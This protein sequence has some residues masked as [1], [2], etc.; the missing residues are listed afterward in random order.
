MQLLRCDNE[1]NAVISL[2]II[3]EMHK[4]YK[5]ALE[6]Q[7]QPFFD[8]VSEMY[9]NM[10]QA[11]RETFDDP[12]SAAPGSQP[13]SPSAD[14]SNESQRVLAKSLY[15]FKVLTDCPMIIA[16]LFNV[17]KAS[18]GAN[19]PQ[20][21]PLIIQVLLLQP[22]AQKKAHDEAAQRGTIFVGVSPEIRN[23]AAYGD[24]KSL[25][26]V[27]FVAYILRMYA[28]YMKPH[29]N[30]VAEAVVSLL[31]DCPPEASVQRKE[32]LVASRHIW[33]TDFRSAFVKHIDTLLN[34]DVLSGTGV[35]SRETLRPLAFAPSFQTSCAKLLSNLIDCLGH[36]EGR[37]L[38]IRILDAFTQK[39]TALS[40]AFTSVVISHHK[41]KSHVAV[42]NENFASH[43]EMD[44]YLDLGYAQ[45]IRTSTKMLDS[46]TDVVKDI[47]TLLKT[48]VGAFKQLLQTLR[49][50]NPQPG[51]NEADV[52][53][54]FS[55]DE[56]QI[57]VRLFCD[58][59]KCF[60]YYIIENFGPDGKLLE[61]LAD[62]PS[63]GIVKEDKEVFEHFAAVFTYVEPS[64]FQEIFSSQIPLLF[65]RI[66]TN[67]GLQAL[68]QYLLGLVNT[69]NA[70][71]AQPNFVAVSPNF[72]GLVLRFLVDRLEMLGAEDQTF[73]LAMLRMFKIVFM[74]VSKY[75][76]RNEGVLRPHVGTIILKSMKLSAKAK[77]PHN[78]FQLLRNL[79]RSIGGGRFEALY[80]EVLPLLEVLLEGLNN[81]LATAHKQQMKELFVELCLT[82]PVRLSVLLPYLSYLMKPLVIALQAGPELVSQGLRTLE[83]C[84][85]NLTQDFLEP[86]LSPVIADL[87]AGLWRH[88]RPL[89]YKTEHSHTTMR[90]LG[91]LGGRNRRL[92][93]ESLRLN[94]K[95]NLESGLD[96]YFVFNQSD[97]PQM[98]SL[99][100]PLDVAFKILENP[101][102]TDFAVQQAFQFAR[103][104]IPLLLDVDEN[105]ADCLLQA[106]IP[107]DHASD[108]S[109]MEIDKPGEESVEPSPFIPPPL[110]SRDKKESFDKALSKVVSLFL[111]ATSLPSLHDAAEK[112]ISNL[113][114]HFAL[115]CISEA[116]DEAKK[117]TKRRG[118]QPTDA[119]LSAPVT[120]IDGFIDAIVKSFTS[121]LPEQ[122]RFAEKALLMFTS[123]CRSLLSSW[124]NVQIDE[125]NVFD[126]LASRFCSCC[127][128]Q[129]WFKKS[130]G[131]HGISI[132]SS[133]LELGTKWM[134][135]HELDFVKALLYVLKDTSPEM[136]S[137]NTED[138][139]ATLSHVLSVCN[140]K[141][142]GESAERQS[143]FSSLISLLISELSNSNSTVRETIQQTFQLLATL[144]ETAVTDLLTPLPKDLLQAGL[145]PILVNLSDFKRLSVSGLEGLARLLELLPNYFKVEVGKK[146][147]DHLRQWADPSVLEDAAGKPLSEIEQIKIMVAILNVFHLLPPTANIFLDDL[148]RN[149]LDLE[150]AMRRSISSPFRPPL[151]KFLNRYAAESVDYFM[152]NLGRQEYGRLF[153]HIIR[154]DLAISLRAELLKSPEKLVEKTFT[155]GE[156]TN[157]ALLRCCYVLILKEMSAYHPNWIC[158][159]P[160]LLKTLR[161]HW[162]FLCSSEEAFENSLTRSKEY[163]HIL[164]IFVGVNKSEFFDVE[165]LY[166]M[167]Q[168]FKVVDIL[169][170]GYLKH[171]LYHDCALTYSNDK[172]KVILEHFLQHFDEASV[173]EKTISLRYMIIPTLLVSFSRNEAH[174]IIDTRT[175]ELIHSRIWHP[176]LSESPDQQI[177]DDS[178]KVELLQL[179][180]LLVQFAPQIINESRRDVIKFAW[181]HLKL[182]DVTCK[183]AAYVLLARFI[184]QYDTP[185]KIVIQIFVALLRAHQ[186]EGRVL[187]KQALDILIPVLPRRI[188]TTANDS[189]I[190]TWVRWTRKI[191]VEEGNTSSQLVTIYQLLIRHAD[192]FYKS[193]DHFIPQIVSSV[194]KLGLLPTA[195]A[196][197]KA[198]TIELGELVLAWERQ[199]AAEADGVSSMED[200][201]RASSDLDLRQGHDGSDSLSSVDFREMLMGY[202]IKFV[203]V[204]VDQ[205]SNLAL[206]SR[207]IELMKSFLDLWPDVNIKFA[208][209]EKALAVELTDENSATLCN[210]IDALGAILERKSSG[211]ILSNI[212]N[213]QR[214]VEV[215]IKSENPQVVK[216]LQLIFHRTYKAIHSLD[217]RESQMS[218]ELTS[219]SKLVEGV[220]AKGLQG[221]TNIFSVVSLV[222]A[223]C[224]FRPEIM[225]EKTL[226]DLMKVL[227]KLT[228]EYLQS[229]HPLHSNGPSPV[230]SPAN[231]IIKMLCLLKDYVPQVKE[232]RK[233]FND[234]LLQLSA[235][236]VDITI[237]EAMLDII[238]SWIKGSEAFPTIKEKA[239]LMVKMMVFESLGDQKLAEEYLNLVATIY[240]TP[241]LARTELTVRLERAFMWGTKS[242]DPTIR[243]TFCATFNSSLDHTL[244]SRLNYIIGIQNWEHLANYFW[245]KQA[246]DLLIGC[247]SSG[248]ELGNCAPGYRVFCS[249]VKHQPDGSAEESNTAMEIEDS[250]AHRA[251]H[252]KFLAGLKKLKMSELLDP[253]R[254]M[255]YTDNE[256][257]SVMWVQLF[258]LCWNILH[259]TERQILSKMLVPLLAKEFHSVQMSLR[260]N[261]IQTLLE[262]ICKCIP[263]IVLP[264]QLVKYLGRSFN[265][266]YTALELLQNMANEH[267]IFGGQN[268]TK[269]DEKIRESTLDALGELLEAV[270]EDDYF[271]GLV[272]RRCLFAETNA[273]VSFEQNGMWAQA[274][275]HYENAQNK[276]RS[277][278]L[279]FSES[280]YNLWETH[281][282][283]SAQRLQQWDILT[284]V[285]KHEGNSEL[286]LECAWRL[287]DWM[288]ER[289][290][291]QKTVEMLPE[292]F[293]SRKKNIQNSGGQDEKNQ[294]RNICDAG[295]QMALKNW[296]ALPVQVSSA[297]I[298][299]LH[300][301]QQFVELGEAAQMQDNLSG[302]QVTNIDTKSQELKGILLTWRERLP[303]MWDDINIWSDLVAWRQHVFTTIN[304]AYLPL[305]PLL[306]Q[307]QGNNN[308]TSSYAY[309]GYHETAWIINRFS[310]VARK[311]QLKEVCHTSLSKIYTLPNIEIPEAFYKLREQAK[312]HFQTPSEYS[313]GLDVIN[314]TNLQFFSHPQRA[315]FFTLKGVFLSKLNLHKDAMEAFSSAIQIEMKLPKAWAAWGQYNDRMFK[316]QPKDIEYGVHA[317]TC[318]LQAA[319][320]Y[321][322]ARSRKYLARILWLLSLDDPQQ[323]LSKSY[324]NFK[325]E[326]PLWYW[327]TFIPQ[328]LTALANKE[329]RYARTVLMKLA[330]SYPQAL[331][332]QLRTAKE[333]YTMIKKNA[334]AT[335][336][337]PSDTPPS[338][339]PDTPGPMETTPTAN[340]TASTSPAA[341]PATTPQVVRRQPWE[342]V[343]EVMALL[344]TAFPLLALSMETM[345]D[346]MAQRL[347][348]TT[349]E[350]IYRL[351][352]LAR[353]PADSGQLCQ[354]TEVNLARF[355]DSMNPNHL[356][357]KA[358]FE[359][360]FIKSKPNLIQLIARFRDWRDKLEI[361]L[362]SRPK[363]QHLEHFSHYL[364]EFEYQ[365]FDDIEVPGQ[366]LLDDP[367]YVTLEEIY[368]EHCAASG[369]HKDAPMLFYID[370]M[371]EFY[372]AE[373]ITKRGKVEILNLKTEIMEEISKRMIPETVLSLVRSITGECMQ[374]N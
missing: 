72:A 179:T 320:L 79:F 73:S 270:A 203:C 120:R 307:P 281:W 211:W 193:K 169:D 332:F 9:Q 223:A 24:F 4:V 315:E 37:G 357:Y 130:G 171:F 100:Y 248:E 135:D 42:Q 2:K 188:T 66:L 122:R 46:S 6:D 69:P 55:E 305:I 132:L 85:D 12:A 134:L 18:V 60:D 125:L 353:D 84:I 36:G 86:I 312:C 317:V 138:A 284:D 275:I 144:T 117:T 290:F 310:H 180:T 28:Q 238:K 373:D 99:D 127:Y 361:L 170:L 328:L 325:G 295:I 309:R 306:S 34:E 324:D 269:E 367:S 226:A 182:D 222:T 228:R 224:A 89:P 189:R 35:T 322:N 47:R 337:R 181:N 326:V 288:T 71:V 204:P 121:E 334:V 342:Y 82:V 7:V 244:F 318:Y 1:E 20:L 319:G 299:L 166:S 349:D 3:S 157:A 54:G 329:A 145:R 220:I 283:S 30:T 41:K 200:V 111:L 67:P 77:D 240:N 366:Y 194:T 115:V 48:V 371:R 258:P 330:K 25:Q 217:A 110:L 113:C 49:G 205:N 131:C 286:L 148:V 327:I 202:V 173:Q 23:R 136:A 142:E 274:Q 151:I 197:T 133:Q 212:A 247:I 362:D 153:V 39:F 364:V 213:I 21:V 262:G 331:H 196:E 346:Q 276:A 155:Q 22:E 227:Q 339:N 251:D 221:M 97:R 351:I 119:I 102:S 154:S 246:I 199:K 19:V 26:T 126:T 65:D 147:L 128:R 159:N 81:L 10:A 11:V 141:G 261:V 207:A 101:G 245:L 243:R 316:E 311:H 163:Q 209:F 118:F 239:N 214:C 56:V 225:E 160:E 29:E 333:D 273:A 321:N 83:L 250:K 174:E 176:S 68:P 96:V 5:G 241:A 265:A 13:V 105:S 345:V 45:P 208:N 233:T 168:A 52:T 374:I 314:N 294:F 350:D 271:F 162:T 87:M 137:A 93:N 190:P 285:A 70:S 186:A 232:H 291:L 216:S 256:L 249:D 95:Q 88:L 231:I 282:V 210:G 63:Q 75:P 292:G 8:I 146:L 104:C 57:F 64:V 257:T 76:D 267:R 177:S 343:E 260:P 40:L 344:K 74:A 215:W 300:T 237:L 152:N 129:E 140:K 106:D 17:H 192:L 296:Y 356:K 340:P 191:I 91:K 253:L 195:T 368:H 259:S 372:A 15:S 365:K 32:L 301:F 264:P 114:Y 323:S 355:A 341:V 279:P 272:K 255:I 112:I 313:L 335:T 62:K 143:K 354:A 92:Q 31:K 109:S 347:K 234:C 338:M 298:P 178:F 336:A 98:I 235:E 287:S 78:Y 80:Q 158:E 150:T 242:D 183:Q 252:K 187:V 59:L 358:A 38:L 236:N 164:E 304:K 27:S 116:V 277:G 123:S 107:G 201:Q 303:N 230:D 369:L 165:I 360:D 266:W 370:R 289:D 229:P 175:I 43:L 254:E 198:L 50:Y 161:V 184:E 219:F 16:M 302:T 293:G 61:S 297:H 206:I 33:F 268:V 278:L 172:K 308:P 167:L 90:I 94:S 348:P 280:E 359:E 108:P 44:G 263:Y 51:G 58:G 124:R 185:S 149:I 139:I 103:S 53:R 156:S 363:R 14:A 352:Q 218:P